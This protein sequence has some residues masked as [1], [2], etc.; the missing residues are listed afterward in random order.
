MTI[1]Y[2]Y[3][4]ADA[5]LFEGMSFHEDGQLRSSF[6]HEKLN[7][8]ITTDSCAYQKQAEFLNSE[9]RINQKQTN[10]KANPGM[11]DREQKYT[12]QQI[13]NAIPKKKEK[14]MWILKERTRQLFQQTGKADRREEKQNLTKKQRNKEKDK[15]RLERN[16]KRKKL[17]KEK[18][19][20]EK[21][22]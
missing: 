4:L 8:K 1:Q 3:E 17:K 22:N 10:E 21:I 16:G 11:H 15:I 20:G 7:S 18:K 14:Q 9:Q 19:K 13:P 12:L 2:R 5:G 6:L